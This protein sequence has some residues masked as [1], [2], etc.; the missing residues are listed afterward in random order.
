MSQQILILNS[1][2]AWI[3]RQLMSDFPQYNYKAFTHLNDAIERGSE[4]EVL[5]AL[6]P[7]IN[8]AL[9]QSMPNLKWIHALTT[10]VDNLV[11]SKAL[12]SNVFLSNSYGFH[13]PQMSELAILLMLSSLR[14]FPQ[15]LD[16]QKQHKW[17]RWPQALMHSKTACIVGVGAIAEDLAKRL[18]AFGMNVI[19]VSDGRNQVDGFDKIYPKYE[20][21]TAASV[22][23]FIVVLVP[24]SAKTH[25]IINDDVLNAMPS[26]SILINLSRGGCVDEVALV[27]HLK[28]NSIRSAALDVFAQEPLSEDSALWDIQNLIITPHIGGM[29]DNY[30]RQVLPQIVKN[31]K[32]WTEGGGI[33]LPG[34]VNRGNI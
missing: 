30:H 26:N 8:D 3:S 1:E 14:D 29:S 19:G 17:E 25:H 32:A 13:G 27:N 11:A 16:N 24:Y 23:D 18:V 6:A 31:L 7:H 2:S 22:S 28:K 5:I 12:G 33:Q 20:L 10:G 15:I 21:N 34:I 9:L 4:C